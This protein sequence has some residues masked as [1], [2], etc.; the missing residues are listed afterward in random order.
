M[1][2]DHRM[3]LDSPR[4]V[5][6]AYDQQVYTAGQVLNK[7]I[8]GSHFSTLKKGLAM[9]RIQAIQQ[10]HCVSIPASPLTSCGILAK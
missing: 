7:P 10:R 9:K 6:R 5:P 1:L 4:Q 2:T 3:V 8:G